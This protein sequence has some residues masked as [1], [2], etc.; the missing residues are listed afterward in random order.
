MCEYVVLCIQLMSEYREIQTQ[1]QELLT[2]WNEPL[3]TAV[4]VCVFVCAL[5]KTC[6][7]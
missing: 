1:K 4:C 3:P 5:L 7:L 6:L 2:S